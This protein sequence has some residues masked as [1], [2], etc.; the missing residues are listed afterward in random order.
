[1]STG[2]MLVDGGIDTTVTYMSNTRPIPNNKE[3]IA[4]CT[5]VAGELLGMKLI[6]MDAG[7]K[8]TVELVQM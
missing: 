3:D 6:Y 2:Y 8:L 1:M 7:Q 5:A 4:V